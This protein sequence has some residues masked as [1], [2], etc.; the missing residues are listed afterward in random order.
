MTKL[1]STGSTGTIGK[2]LP[3]NVH[4]LKSD[5]SSGKESFYGVNFETQ[6]NL[7]HLAGVVGLMEVLKDI[8]Y[9]RSVNISGS[10]FLAEEFIKKSEGIFYYVST[11][12]VYAPSLDLI[13]ESN[14]LA[15]ANIYAEQK[16]EAES[17]LRSIFESTPKRLCIIRVFSVLD[18]DVAPFTLGGGIRKLAST[19]SDFVLSNSSDIRDFLT[20]KDIANALFEIASNG[21]QFETV[22]LC[23]GIGISV[24]DAAKRMLS[25][26]G[27]A[28]AEDRFS[29][30][31]GSNPLVVGDNSLLISRHPNLKLSWRPSTLN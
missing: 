4:P 1:Y 28:V 18:W 19:N 25:E 9:A 2:H 10:Q 20:P 12:H 8:G 6:S 27:F 24:G 16:L 26:S 31:R 14:A 15:P 11:S 5:L 7:I 17:L 30:G 22:N 29:W 23:T 21:T 3:N 13:S